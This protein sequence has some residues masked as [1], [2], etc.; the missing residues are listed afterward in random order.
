[1][2]A[3][4]GKNERTV[5]SSPG[6]WR[7]E[8]ID[9]KSSRND[10]MQANEVDTIAPHSRDRLRTP[11]DNGE[12]GAANEDGRDVEDQRAWRGNRRAEIELKRSSSSSFSSSGS[13]RK[14]KST[15]LLVGVSICPETGDGVGIEEFLDMGDA[16]EDSGAGAEKT[17]RSGEGVGR[18]EVGIVVMLKQAGTSSTSCEEARRKISDSSFLSSLR[19]RLDMAPKYEILGLGRT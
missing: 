7:K 18:A 6:S 14:L 2:Y 4:A 3:T 10:K 17:A 13:G 5:P 19:K 9:K 16:V 11:A 15:I 12:A 1:M 8:R